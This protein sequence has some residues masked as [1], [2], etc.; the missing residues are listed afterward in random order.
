MNV[1]VIEK[2]EDSKKCDLSL[3]LRAK[4]ESSSH[5]ML[6]AFYSDISAS[7]LLVVVLGVRK[8]APQHGTASPQHIT[9]TPQHHNT[10]APPSGGL[11]NTTFQR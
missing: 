8:I 4:S 2:K 3:N 7:F 11:L 1:E 9:T 5:W 6:D 10:T